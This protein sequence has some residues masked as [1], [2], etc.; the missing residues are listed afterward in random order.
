M[1]IM[2]NNLTNLT[3]SR[4][5]GTV[6]LPDGRLWISGGYDG[7]FDQMATSVVMNADG[8]FEDFFSLPQ[9]MSSQCKVI[10]DDTTA[11]IAGGYGLTT[12]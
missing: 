5:F 1:L 8:D 7:N 2:I 12:K 4:A 3:I 9:S 11:I 10:V 6:L